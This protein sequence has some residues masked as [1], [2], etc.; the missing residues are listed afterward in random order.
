MKSKRKSENTQRQMKLE[1][2]LSKIYGMQQKQFQELLLVTQQ[3]R[4]SSRKK[5]NFKEARLPPERSRKRTNKPQSPQKESNQEDRYN[6]VEKICETKCFLKKIKL[7]NLQPD[8][9]RR[10]MRGTK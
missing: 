4:L 2:Q 10:K 7:I 6:K 5:E 1:T 9:P 8:S 3:H